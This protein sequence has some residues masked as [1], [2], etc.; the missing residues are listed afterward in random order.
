MP[1]LP[2][3]FQHLSFADGVRASTARNP[4]KLALQ[5]KNNRRTY[6][7]LIERIDRVTNAIAGDLALGPGDHG[8]I[9]SSNCIDYM[10]IVIG[11]AQAGLALATVNPR[12]QPAE[13]VTIC[14]D[15]EAK[16]IFADAASAEA[17]KDQNF[18][19]VK[20][21]IVIG[22]ELDDWL[23][24]VS[25]PVKPIAVDEWEVFTIPYTSGTTGKPKGVLVPHRSRVLTLFSMAVEYG[26]YSPDDRFLAMAPMCHGAGMVYALAPIFFGGFAEILDRFDPELFLKRLK[27]ENI[28]GYFAVP[29]HFHGIFSL[30]KSVLE[31]NRCES[32][33][34]IISNAAPLA[35]SSKEQIIDYFGP[36]MLHETYGSTEA[37]IVTNLRPPDQ[38]R[39]QRC[40]GL[41]F[42]MTEVKLVNDDGAECKPDEVGELFSKSPF[43]FNGYWNRPKETE[44]SYK[45]GWV[46]VEDLARRD[47][48]GYIYIIDRKKDMVISGGIN[49]YPREIEEVLFKHPAIADVAVT[50]VPDEKWGERL[51]AFVVARPGNDIAEQDVIDFCKDKISDYKVPKD[52][53]FLEALPRNVGG[54]V[55]KR[56]LRD[57]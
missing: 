10:E 44:A 9:I 20:R 31:A 48:E 3:S 53:A 33:H 25:L 11:A 52:V 54:K 21:I 49:I 7:Q 4:N 23:G 40:V 14:D 15:A 47:D 39:K 57:M 24:K 19:T 5:H 41:P 2:R 38:L 13:I 12:L 55:L 43:L 30:E 8:A 42:P 36:G 1:D 50:G 51:K 35:Q 18:E 46:T 34:T 27:A 28:T 45:D 26:C 22:K 17:I 6:A 16:V 32:L 29:T 56:E 37:G